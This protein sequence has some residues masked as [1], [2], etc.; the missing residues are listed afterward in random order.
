MDEI[1]KENANDALKSVNATVLL[2]KWKDICDFAKDFL[3]SAD[4]IKDIL[5]GLDASSTLL[6][7]GL[8]DDLLDEIYT[9]SPFVRNRLTLMRILKLTSI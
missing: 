2:S 7:I 8:S 9:L 6:D 4:F 5:V 1:I 3:P